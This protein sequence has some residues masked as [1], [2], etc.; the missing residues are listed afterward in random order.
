MGWFLLERFYKFIFSRKSDFRIANVRLSV[1]KAPQ[2]Q[3]H[4]YQPNLSLL[5]IMPISHNANQPPSPPLSLSESKLSA[6]MPIS[7][8]AHTAF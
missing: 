6:I 8:H 1:T 7:Y 2:P 4:A 3:N 5:A